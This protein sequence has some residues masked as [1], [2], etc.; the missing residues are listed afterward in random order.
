MMGMLRIEG[1]SQNDVS[2]SPIAVQGP[3]VAPP[4][5]RFA[6]ADRFP[7]PGAGVLAARFQHQRAIHDHLLDPLAVL[8]WLVVCRPVGDA[9]RIE[10]RH[11][12]EVR[13]ASGCR[14]R[15]VPSLAAL[16]EVILR[17]A[18]SSLSSFL[19]ADV[20]AEDAGEGAE[21]ARMRVAAPQAALRSRRPSRPSRSSTTAA[22][23]PGSCPS[24]CGARTPS[25]PSR[26]ARSAGRTARPADRAAGP[27]PCARTAITRSIVSPS[28]VPLPLTSIRLQSPPTAV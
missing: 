13:R 18:S 10:N 24:R 7:R 14:D 25:A 26:P 11:V 12:G 19:L 8:K 4:I 1:L 2:S 28:Y 9:F 27:C 21:V 3:F 16:S 17:T 23:A 6:A 20:N 22:P 5:L 15:R